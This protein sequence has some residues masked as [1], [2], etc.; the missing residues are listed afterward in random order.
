MDTEGAGR[1]TVQNLLAVFD[2]SMNP[3][4]I[5]QRKTKDQIVTEFLNNFSAGPAISWEEFLDYYQDLSMNLP[6]DEYFVRLLESTWQCPEDDK[7]PYLKSTVAMLLKEV[8]ARV[9]ELA[10]GDAKLLR[11]LHADFDL[12]GTGS[13]TIDEVTNLIAK[14]KVAVE[15]KYV[16]PFFKVLDANNSGGVEFDEF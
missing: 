11:K 1:V 9:Q 14:L 16:Y 15:R 5:E 3:D 12:R 8:R 4:F 7:D 6:S 2:V 10:K 13:L